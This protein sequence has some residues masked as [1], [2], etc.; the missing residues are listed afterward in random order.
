M[1]EGL[2]GLAHSE[3]GASVAL[4]ERRLECRVL[5]LRPT[6]ARSGQSAKKRLRRVRFTSIRALLHQLYID[7]PA[8]GAPQGQ[9]PS[10]LMAAP[11]A[12]WRP[13]NNGRRETRSVTA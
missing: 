7:D 3:I 8:G 13:H 11:V 12:A 4:E 2:R 6:G 5:P 1:I 9:G 10:T